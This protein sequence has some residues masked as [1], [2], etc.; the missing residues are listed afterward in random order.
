MPNVP[1]VAVR[2]LGIALAVL[3]VAAAIGAYAVSRVSEVRAGGT[4]VLVEGR[5]VEGWAAPDLQYAGVVTVVD[6]CLAIR[7]EDETFAAVWPRGSEVSGTDRSVQVSG[8]AVGTAVLYGRRGLTRMETWSVPST[9]A[10]LPVWVV[11]DPEVD[12]A[13]D[14]R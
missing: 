9:C 12:P 5:P 3:L 7:Q 14:T 4:T 6:G 8:L 1:W 2:R 13:A 11:L 10:D